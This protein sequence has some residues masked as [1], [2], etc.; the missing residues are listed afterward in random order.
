MYTRRCLLVALLFAA[1]AAR[2]ATAAQ[3]QISVKTIPATPLVEVG[4]DQQLLNF[5]MV[6]E[7]SGAKAL[8]LRGIVAEASDPAG[9]PIAR[10]L[11]SENGFPSS[12][13]TLPNREV[14]AHGSLGI[15]N[16]LFAWPRGAN[17]ARIHYTLWVEPLV[18]RDRTQL[19]F[20]LKG[21]VFVLDGHDFYSHHRRQDLTAPEVVGAGIHA[22]PVRYCDDFVFVDAHGAMFAGDPREKKNW[23]GY[24]QPVYAPAGGTVVSIV[25]DVGEPTWDGRQLH[26]PRPP[27]DDSP[28]GNYVLI[29]HGDGELSVLSHLL[30]HSIRVRRGDHVTQGQLVGRLGASESGNP[31][32]PVVAHL[33]YALISGADYFNSEG[34]PAY[35]EHYTLLLGSEQVPVTNGPLDTGDFFKT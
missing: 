11:L 5:D 13:E 29:D 33:A 12:M 3:N 18:Y 10:T 35:F 6:I 25:N 9:L 23:F 26:K 8:Q 24:G 30:P 31:E 34:L 21:R 7:N 1:L 27:A 32:Y 19:I 17:I 16:P 14:P 22:N 2:P 15:F 20:P 4:R 28:F